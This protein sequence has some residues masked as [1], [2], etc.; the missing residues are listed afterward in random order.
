MFCLSSPSIT[1]HVQFKNWTPLSGRLKTFSKLR[2]YLSLIYP[3]DSEEI[4]INPGTFNRLLKQMIVNKHSNQRNNLNLQNFS[5]LDN[6][7]VKESEILINFEDD[8]KNI[9]IPKDDDELLK[10]STTI[11]KN[12]RNEKISQSLKVN[13]ISEIEDSDRINESNKQTEHFQ[14][15]TDEYKY[16]KGQKIIEEEIEED[17]QNEIFPE[18]PEKE[19]NV[20]VNEKQNDLSDLDK[21]EYYMKSQYE[22][23]DYDIK[24]LV[25]R[26]VIRDSHPIRA[27]TFSPRGDYFALGTNSKSV[28]L[29][30]MKNLIKGLKSKNSY[31]FKDEGEENNNS[32]KE[33]VSLIFEQKN[34]H[35]GSIYCLD[36]SISG[37][38][39]ASGSNDKLVKL[40]VIPDLEESYEDKEGETLELTIT[41]HKGTVRSVSFEPTSDLVLLSSGTV[42]KC[43]KVWDAEK[44][45]NITNLEGHTNDIN[46]I[47]WSNDALICASSGAD[48]TIR[49]WDLRDY[50]CTFLISA[51]KYSDINDI[52]IFSKHKSRVNTL[53][54]AGHVDGSVTV[55][56]YNKKSVLK[57]LN[58]HTSEVR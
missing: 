45:T 19:K 53:V 57:E 13:K 41:G 50:K 39:I 1:N 37:R 40:M 29:F 20:F 49:F 24:S 46:T 32:T 54:A 23:Y 55:W 4:K 36:W 6:F 38:L 18:V 5:L 16:E 2:E 48:K 10:K 3:I 26:K 27:C 34:H 52:S 43:I 11:S 15:E 35:L 33:S 8:Q 47:K 30:R 44:G 25:E 21:E 28:K 17:F 12:L 56:D 31:N 9:K 22:Y 58:G 14:R 7:T 51:L 42:D